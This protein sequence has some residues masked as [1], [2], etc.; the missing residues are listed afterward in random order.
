M[1]DIEADLLRKLLNSF[2]GHYVEIRTP[3]TLH[4]IEKIS[5]SQKD[6]GRF[7]WHAETTGNTF[8]SMN[9]NDQEAQKSFID[10]C[11]LFPRLYF[12]QENLVTEFFM[13]CRQRNLT[14]DSIQ[15]GT[16]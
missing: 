11:D 15:M 13:W 8:A 14:I 3:Y 10:T 5:L 6:R 16:V 4:H 1:Y 2:H 7:K 9:N 12:F